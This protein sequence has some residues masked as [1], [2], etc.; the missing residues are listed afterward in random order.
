M[1]ELTEFESIPAA[2]AGEA[3]PEI[4][5]DAGRGGGQERRHH[6]Q[7][8]REGRRQACAAAAAAAATEAPPLPASAAAAEAPAAAGADA[9]GDVRPAVVA[10]VHVVGL[11]NDHREL[12]GVL[13]RAADEPPRL[14]ALTS[15]C[16]PAPAG[17]HHQRKSSQ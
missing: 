9:V 8:R 1:P 2:V 13:R 4:R 5:G 10:T 12:H 7:V 3:R 14:D 15:E 11:V 17:H 16:N 6:P